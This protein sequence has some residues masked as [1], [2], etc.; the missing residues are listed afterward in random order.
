MGL[1]RLVG[2]YLIR[3]DS[4]S[5]SFTW[6]YGRNTV[7]V[8]TPIYDDLRSDTKLELAKFIIQQKAT[9]SVEKRIKLKLR[10]QSRQI[11]YLLCFLYFKV[12]QVLNGK[13]KVFDSV[14]MGE[15]ETERYLSNRQA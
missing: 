11:S 5:N 12:R 8:K 14:I 13:K 15:R 2:F 10:K 4:V 7:P 9:Q 1:C 6:E 3:S